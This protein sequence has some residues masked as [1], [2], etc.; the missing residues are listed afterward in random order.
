MF[1]TTY[2]HPMVVHFPIALIIGGLLADTLFIIYKQASWL[3]KAGFSLMILGTLGACAAFLTGT[4]FTS[5][6][7]EGDIVSV[8]E[9]H[10]TLAHIT[11]TI[12]LMVSLLRIYAVIKHK[13]NRLKWIIYGL[14]LI[15]TVAVSATA[16]FGGKM[17]YSYMLGI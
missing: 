13:E 1:E 2:F 3:S 8:F 4:L 6:P 10:H 11:L 9:T 15:G 5:E 16:F 17:V 14:F 7:T 12:M